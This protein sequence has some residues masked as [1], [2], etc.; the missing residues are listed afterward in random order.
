MIAAGAVNVAWARARIPRALMS[1]RWPTTE[2]LIVA[3]D[4]DDAPGKYQPVCEYRYEVNGVQ[5]R[6]S[7]ISFAPALDPRA[8]ERALVIFHRY[9]PDKRVTVYYDPHHP[10]RSVLEPG[11]TWPLA[12]QLVGGVGLIAL[13][14]VLPEW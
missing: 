7:R 1:T 3:R 13:A 5:F 10:H 6:G 9:P 8:F 12:A 11:V 2:G 14:L 4:L